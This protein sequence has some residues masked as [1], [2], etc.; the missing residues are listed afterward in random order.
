M[1]PLRKLS[2]NINAAT[3]ARTPPVVSTAGDA[4][5]AGG[6]DGEEPQFV[7]SM[8][9]EDYELGNPIGYGSSAIVYIAKYLPINKIVAVKVIELDMF[10]RNQIDELRASTTSFV[11]VL[12]L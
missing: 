6:G 2:A 8:R 1:N 10:E 12:Q 7:F 9:F 11:T 5:S 3:A 4:S